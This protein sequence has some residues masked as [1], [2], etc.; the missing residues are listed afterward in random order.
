[1]S[2][3]A[4]RKAIQSLRARIAE[5]EQKIERERAKSEPNVGLLTHWE[6]EIQAFT[7]RLRRLEDRLAQRRQR[8]KTS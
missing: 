3:R 1:V 5:H 7:V 8:G 4:I 6:R 2:N